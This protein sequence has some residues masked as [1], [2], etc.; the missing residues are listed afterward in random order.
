GISGGDFF[1]SSGTTAATIA[2]DPAIAAAPSK[3]AAAK[4]PGEVGDATIA[5]AIGGLRGDASVDVAYRQLVTQIGSDSQDAH[6]SLA[7]A[8][9]LADALSSRRD[10]ISGV[11]LDEEMTNLMR[12][13]RGFQASS[14]ALNA[15]DEMV[16]L[17]VTRTGRVGL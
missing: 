12:F 4:A 2:V 15:M 6:G 1:V 14:R 7:N 5:L 10:S 11:S 8:K 16:E 9:L 17:L 13:Q 3:V